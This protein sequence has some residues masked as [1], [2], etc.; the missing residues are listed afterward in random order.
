MSERDDSAPK[1]V[2][3]PA[4]VRSGAMVA[5]RWLGRAKALLVPVGDM[6]PAGSAAEHLNDIRQDTGR[7]VVIGWSIVGGLLGLMLF[8]STV[9]SIEGAVIAQ[10]QVV[11]DDNARKVQ[12][13]E[14]GIVKA[15]N[16]RN[17]DRVTSGQVI[18]SLDDTTVRANLAIIERQLVDLAAREARLRAEMAENETIP[19]PRWPMADYLEEQRKTVLAGELSLMKSRLN[20]Q[21]ARVNQVV[22]KRAQTRELLDGLAAQQKSKTDE[23]AL[24]DRELSGLKGLFQRGL[25][26]IQRLTALERERARLVGEAGRL[27]SDLARTRGQATEL[28]IQIIELDERYRSEIV[29]E[30]R[31]TEGKI[32][33][34]EERRISIEDRLNRIDVVAPITGVVHQSEVNTVGGVINPSQMLMLIVPDGDPLVVE[35]KLAP[36][37]IEQVHPGQ[38]AHIRLTAFNQRTTPEFKGTVLRVSPDL[39]TDSRTGNQYFTARVK[40]EDAAAVGRTLTPG[41]PVETYFRT[42]SNSV[43]SYLLKPLTD[44]FNRALRER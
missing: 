16:A 15:I 2:A 14:G 8:W 33:E 38:P 34:L 3:L 18:L 42:Q 26:G 20:G 4:P 29:N 39:L 25:A 17:G 12:H 24:I 36:M 40:P 22:E 23:I 21:R 6:V 9:A 37:D 28:E 1:L 19:T 13:Q 41:M 32:A 35:V 43:M 7:L 27:L 11:V 10:G 5:A 30:L 44:N 31:Q